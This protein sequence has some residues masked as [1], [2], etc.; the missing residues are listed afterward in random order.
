[1]VRAIKSSAK[2][3]T[4]SQPDQQEESL[5][6][7]VIRLQQ[8]LHT[9]KD[10]KNLQIEQLTSLIEPLQERASELE[11]QLRVLQSQHDLEVKEINCLLNESEGHKSQLAERIKQLETSK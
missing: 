3:A 10:D 11:L 6:E 5:E 7:K 1:M 2:E 4:A 9:L 8:E